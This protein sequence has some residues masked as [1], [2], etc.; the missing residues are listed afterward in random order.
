MVESIKEATVGLWECL[1]IFLGIIL[2][3]TP[4]VAVAY[5]LLFGVRYLMGA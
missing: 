4:F 5:L 3:L 1:V 2:F